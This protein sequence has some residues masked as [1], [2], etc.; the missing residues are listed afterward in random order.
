MRR[1]GRNEWT[2]EAYGVSQEDTVV[3]FRTTRMAVSC[4]SCCL[5]VRRMPIEPLAGTQRHLK[6]SPIA[7][8]SRDGQKKRRD[9]LMKAMMT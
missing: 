9:R 1:V 2:H 4:L 5:I 3:N 6:E 7:G 8:K